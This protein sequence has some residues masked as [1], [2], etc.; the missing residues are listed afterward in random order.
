[1]RRHVL[2][3]IASA[4]LAISASAQQE[5][6]GADRAKAGPWTQITIA[7]K[8]IGGDDVLVRK[9]TTYVSVPA[10]AQA[11]DASIASQ[12]QVAVL[13]IPAT[14]DA[15]C[16]NTPD[17]KRLSDEYR[18]AAV[19][20]PDAIES[21]RV[22]VAKPAEVIPAAS[23]DEIDRQI[24]EAEYRAHT[25]ADKSVSYALSHANNTLAI[26]Y[27]K[28]RRGISPEFAKRGQLDS[29][30]CSMESKFALQAGRLSGRESCSVFH[31]PH[32]EEEKTAASD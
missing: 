20:I 28:L 10:L 22:Q 17:A 31:Y 11:L 1:M 25:D 8:Q 29:V 27:Y 5:Q 24:S 32:Q 2:S 19:H 26:L 15:D 13:S 16:G 14:S 6:A 4:V 9:G 30:L 7:G 21:L 12:G 18:K 23:F 3:L